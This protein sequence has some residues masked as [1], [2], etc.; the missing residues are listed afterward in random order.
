[1]NMD[2]APGLLEKIESERNDIKELYQIVIP[3]IEIM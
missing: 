3:K 2:P 1:M